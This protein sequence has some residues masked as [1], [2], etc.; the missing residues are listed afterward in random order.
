MEDL[1]L[2]KV[3]GLDIGSNSIGAAL[4]EVPEK[5]EEYGKFG[6]IIF[7]TSRIILTDTN[8]LNHFEQGEKLETPA[9]SRTAKRS[10][11]RRIERYKL[12]RARLTMVLRHLGW[13]PQ[14]FP[15]FESPSKI[16][17][18]LF[19]ILNTP[20]ELREHNINYYSLKISD[21][22]KP[23]DESIQEF[24]QEFGIDYNISKEFKKLPDDWIVYYLRKKGL[25][26][27]LSYSEL[28]LILY[29]LNQRRG[30][31]SSRKDLKDTEQVPYEKFEET[32]KE[33]P[34]SKIETKFAT[35]TKIVKV[36]PVYDE[37]GKPKISKGKTIYRINVDDERVEPWDDNFEKEPKIVGKEVTLVVTKKYDKGKITQLKPKEPDENNWDLCVVAQDNKMGLKHPGEYF[38][39]EILRAY[40]DNKHVKIR[41]YAVYRAKY[42]K[43][44]TEIWKKQLE[45]NPELATL[46][47][48]KQLMAELAQILYPA[49]SKIKAGKYLE[50][51]NND[52]FHVIFNDIIYYHRK[53]KSQKHLISECPFERRQAIKIDKNGKKILYDI[54]GLKCIPKSSPLFQEFVAWK[55]INNLKLY[56]IEGK[57]DVDV[58]EKYLT[59]DVKEKL[60]EVF[61]RKSEVKI[62]DILKTI[63]E[64]IPDSVNYIRNNKKKGEEYN[65][66]INLV[67][68]DGEIKGNQTVSHYL[69]LLSK[70]TD[71]S[72]DIISDDEFI[73][74]LWHLEYSQNASTL[75]DLKENLS[76]GLRK[77]AINY[78]EIVEK[79]DELADL[80]SKSSLIGDKD[81]GGFS[82]LAIKKMLI[83]MRCGKYWKDPD[84]LIQEFKQKLNNETNKKRAKEITNFITFLEK[85]K[86]QAQNIKQR[87]D[88]IR[89]R[90]LKIEE[91]ADDIVKKQVIKSFMEKENLEDFYKGLKEH[92]ATYLIYDQ[93]SEKRF[94]KYLSYEDISKSINELEKSAIKNPIVK[95]VIRETLLLIRD[96]WEKFG[97][98]D[99]IHIELARELRA[100]SEQRKQIAE[101]MRN[102]EKERERARQMLI[103]LVNK[104]YFKNSVIPNPNR[105]DD[106]R[107]FLIYEQQVKGFY[108]KPKDKEFLTYAAWLEQNCISP[109]TGKTIPLS[110]LF[111]GT[112]YQLEHIIPRARYF[113]NSLS[114]LVVCESY[115]NKAKGNQ[116]AAVFIK[117]SNGRCK[118]GDKFYDL[119]TY[120]DYVAQCKNLFYYKNKAK[121]KN[122]LAEEVPENF[123]SRQLNDTRYIN[124]KLAEMLRPIPR[125]E[126][127]VIVT[128]GSITDMLKR[129]WGLES[130]W[131]DMMVPRF[132]RMERILEN[133]L[134]KD[135]ISDEKRKYL[136]EKLALIK[137]NLYFIT[138][139]NDT[140]IEEPELA[141]NE[142]IDIKRL[143]HRHHALDAIVIALTNRRHI[144]LI[145]TIHAMDESKKPSYNNNNDDFGKIYKYLEKED[146]I[147]Y[148]LPWINLPFDTK[149]ALDECMV[150]FK[151]KNKFITKPVNKI[152]KWVEQN[153][154]LEKAFVSQEKNPR[155]MAVRCQ[156]F[157][158]QPFGPI[159]IKYVEQKS[160]SDAIK[161][162]LK[163]KIEKASHLEVGYVYD[164]HARE[165]IKRFI[166]EITN[167]VGFQKIEDYSNLILKQIPKKGKNYILDGIE[168]EKIPV[169]KFELNKAKRKALSKEM[170]IKYLR[171]KV[172]YFFLDKEIFEKYRDSYPKV[173]QK[174]LNSLEDKK[175]TIAYE[176]ILEHLIQYND[177][178]SKAFSTEGQEELNKRA[179]ANPKFQK[180]IN[181]VTILDGELD[182]KMLRYNS[183]FETDTNVYFTIAEDPKTKE[184]TNNKSIRIIEVLDSKLNGKPLFEIEDGKKLLV[185]KPYD[186]VYV[187]TKEEIEQIKS[188]AEINEVI[189][190]NNKKKI[191]E[192]CYYLASTAENT[193]KAKILTFANFL[194]KPEKGFSGEV[195]WE[196]KTKVALD[197]DTDIAKNCIKLKVNRLGNFEPIL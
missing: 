14:D 143:D 161:I 113:D 56:L 65:V 40:K 183:Y 57:Y 150:T 176:L 154:R 23:S 74:K 187:P 46:N 54:R 195:G 35:I 111:D 47:Q 181:A 123:I 95:S 11:R 192:R 25:H 34:D 78:P 126:Q 194:I 160:L 7:T 110:K 50:F 184:R 73:Y 162:E 141:P 19:E 173:Y 122:L 146:K 156:I 130:L 5:N 103:E 76:K 81:Y 119:L 118:D 31:K 159:W 3:L 147:K 157:K 132:K 145:N 87:I 189:D 79:A 125:D 44:I 45:L 69:N 170:N 29:M 86:E 1:K 26:K 75:D 121:Y 89:N 182:K 138:K 22:L 102:K 43:E 64:V 114:N 15:P 188:G 2:K 24:Y 68:K 151:A 152:L 175:N 179:L 80:M 164:K 180:T 109:Y 83:V 174:Y 10:M 166:D 131:K 148:T 16:K 186:I 33:K 112:L 185:F 61:K 93:H 99:E 108:N 53:L 20:K 18:K 101:N 120:D 41:Q 124:R 134:D 105:N 8:L 62:N 72:N 196:N 142:K 70:I 49:Q 135:D 13:L 6:R 67:N 59:E 155:W 21:F 158:E 153:G 92:Q 191:I 91:V 85:V 167:E 133:E 149:N 116:L 32:I 38:F 82:A 144:Q 51:L 36:E 193:F 172:P 165:V 98:I 60:F 30:F 178:A 63:N 94:Q 9:K 177:D 136:E 104:G 48:N 4:V 163:R 169:A 77:I 55:N 100:S 12:R 28:A 190:W 52:L 168:Y 129:D 171:D 96:I 37:E 127:G 42:I 97:Y 90:T 88:L 58:T 84:I 107:K 71:K 115:I 128:T 66:R 27:K 117:N 17:N 140:I 139:H 39:D 137:K 197:E 106:I